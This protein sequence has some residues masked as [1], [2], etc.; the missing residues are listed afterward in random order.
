MSTGM[1]IKIVILQVDQETLAAALRLARNDVKRIQ[2]EVSTQE[3]KARVLAAKF[4]TLC[5]K[6]APA[7]DCQSSDTS[8]VENNFLNLCLHPQNRSQKR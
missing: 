4:E 7:S 6:R 2:K 8:M 3:Q 5:L 1:Q